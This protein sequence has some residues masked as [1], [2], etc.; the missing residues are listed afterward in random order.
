MLNSVGGAGNEVRIG[1]SGLR[2]GSRLVAL[3]ILAV[4]TFSMVGCSNSDSV[5]SNAGAQ[6]TDFGALNYLP[7][8]A[9]YS[10]SYVVTDASGAELRRESYSA[11]SVVFVDG[12]SG[13][14]W[15]QRNLANDSVLSEGTMYWNSDKS[16]L[17][18]SDNNSTKVERLLRSPL[19]EEAQWPR[20]RE[21]S[22]VTGGGIIIGS[23]TDQLGD[24]TAL[25]NNL[26]G[27][28]ANGAGLEID[29][30][31]PYGVEDPQFSSFPTQGASTFFVGAMGEDLI[32]N[33]TLY[34]DCLLIETANSDGT[35]NRYWYCVGVGLVQ[36][37]LSSMPDEV[38]GTVNGA[39][40]N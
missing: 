22:V 6:N 37:A 25:D 1:V 17:F 26:P 34:N 20:W 35:I 12:Y 24:N 5:V 3:A 2:R 16:I 27:D 10:A 32:V 31:N 33:G 15:V 11:D 28:G 36:Y 23:G 39:L 18:H 38:V 30:D 9:G 7:V 19:E 13:V 14:N 21:P 29:K 40:I 4:S 8:E